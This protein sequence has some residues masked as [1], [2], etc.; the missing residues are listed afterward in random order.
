MSSSTGNNQVLDPKIPQSARDAIVLKVLFE[1]SQLLGTG[2]DR[3]TLALCIG[4]IEEGTNPIAL[5]RVVR[6]LKQEAQ[7]RSSSS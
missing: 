5:A 3:Q 2:I 7:R 4:M 6:E 1:I